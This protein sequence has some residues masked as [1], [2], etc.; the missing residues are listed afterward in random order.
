MLRIPMAMTAE[1]LGDKYG[2]TRE[3]T[4]NFTFQSLSR[5][6]KGRLKV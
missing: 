2:I 3:E 6:K 4:D 5:W 1:K